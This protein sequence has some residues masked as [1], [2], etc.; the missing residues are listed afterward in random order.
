MGVY[1]L[2]DQS[3]TI[4]EQPSR[5]PWAI[6]MPPPS[7]GNK[8]ES[9]KIRASAIEAFSLPKVVLERVHSAYRLLSA[10]V[11]KQTKVI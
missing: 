8:I 1:F 2:K 9:I 6:A 11:T 7:S 4:R 3:D 10:E 5:I